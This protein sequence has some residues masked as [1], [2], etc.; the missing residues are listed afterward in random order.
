MMWLLQFFRQA[1]SSFV[2]LSVT[3]VAWLYLNSI[4]FDLGRDLDLADY[5]NLQNFLVSIPCNILPFFFRC[6]LTFF[7]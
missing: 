4:S 6:N 5:A 1:L 7:V 2:A 3:V